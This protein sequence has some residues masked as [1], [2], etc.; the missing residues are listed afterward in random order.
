MVKSKIANL[1]L[2]ICILPVCLL[3]G[4]ST[5]F[6]PQELSENY[7]LADGVRCDAPAVVDGDLETTS[8]SR[9][10]VISLPEAKPIRRVIIHSPN[11]SNFILYES[12]GAEGQWRIIKSVKGNKLDKIVVS[13]QVTTDKIR[14]Y[15]SDTRGSRFV[16]PGTMI[17]ETGRR[18]LF[19]RK[20][21]TRPVIQ[22]IELYGL[23][24][25]VDKIDLQAPLF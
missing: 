7:A 12:I 17:D 9:R 3:A 24:D 1:G 23:V 6:A 25:S 15:V 14:I 5:L 11:V 21:D 2:W 19:T 16:N 13:T 8:E 18:N 22:E 4:C 10:I 20:V